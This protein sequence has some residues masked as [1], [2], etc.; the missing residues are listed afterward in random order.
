M[1]KIISLQ[2]RDS[3]QQIIHATQLENMRQF[4]NCIAHGNEKEAFEYVDLT[5]NNFKLE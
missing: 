3:F 4:M 5:R 2:P 1:N